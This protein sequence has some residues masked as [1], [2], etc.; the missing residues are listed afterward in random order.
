MIPTTLRRTLLVVLLLASLASLF[1]ASAVGSVPM[2]IGE[3]WAAIGDPHS[4]YG[5]LVWQLRMPRAFAAWV[6]GCLLAMSGCL[7]QVLLRN[8]LAD[9]YVL[10]VS[11]GAAFAI[12]L[13]MVAGLAAALLP[14]L[15]MLGALASMVN[16]VRPPSMSSITTSIQ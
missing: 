9:P 10:G 12:L 6:V 4:R 14:W 15:A 8:P 1:L 5:E 16:G 13:G 3:W 2:T 11:G 7:M